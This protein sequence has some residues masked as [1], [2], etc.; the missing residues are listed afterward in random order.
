MPLKISRV[1]LFCVHSPSM[2]K[3]GGDGDVETAK[4]QEGRT[5]PATAGPGWT[6]VNCPCCKSEQVD[7]LV[8]VK[9]GPKVRPETKRWL[10]RVIGAPQQEGG[11]PFSRS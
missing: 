2:S 9:L 5:A 7:P 8:L 1:N 4:L 6:K 10:L 3:A 11:E